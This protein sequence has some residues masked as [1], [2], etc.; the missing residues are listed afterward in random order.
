VT[1]ALDRV[2]TSRKP[3]L[4]ESHAKHKG[5]PAS[6]CGLRGLAGIRRF[7]AAAMRAWWCTRRTGITSHY[8]SQQVAQMD[9][10]RRGA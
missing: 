6:P 2:N 3:G 4:A 10:M 8:S 7:V 1:T 5:D 9:N